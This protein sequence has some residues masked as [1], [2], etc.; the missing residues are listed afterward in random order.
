M[1]LNQ[2]TESLR[3]VPAID[4]NQILTWYQKA[5]NQSENPGRFLGLDEQTKRRFEFINKE[6]LGDSSSIKNDYG[7]IKAVLD[8]LK[9]YFNAIDNTSQKYELVLFDLINQI[10]RT[11]LDFTPKFDFKNQF[12]KFEAHFKTEKLE[13]LNLGQFFK[14]PTVTYST[15]NFICAFRQIITKDVIEKLDKAAEIDET[16]KSSNSSFIYQSELE[17]CYLSLIIKMISSAYTDDALSGVVDSVINTWLNNYPFRILNSKGDFTPDNFFIS[18]NTYIREGVVSVKERLRNY[19]DFFNRLRNT[20]TPAKVTIVS[21]VEFLDL[22]D[23]SNTY[24][25]GTMTGDDK[26]PTKPMRSVYFREDFDYLNS[27]LIRG[28][29]LNRTFWI[30]VDRIVNMKNKK[31]GFYLLLAN[32]IKGLDEFYD[33][34]V[35]DLGLKNGFT[36]DMDDRMERYKT[37]CETSDEKLELILKE[38]GK[39]EEEPHVEDT[40]E[41]IDIEVLT[42]TD[43]NK[44]LNKNI[45]YVSK[46]IVT[47]NNDIYKMH[48]EYSPN[49]KIILKDDGTERSYN[50]CYGSS[51]DFCNI[52][53]YHNLRININSSETLLK[54]PIIKV[55][56]KKSITK[57]KNNITEVIDKMIKDVVDRKVRIYWV[58]FTLQNIL[59]DG[60]ILSIKTQFDVL[61]SDPVSIKNL[62]N[63]FATHDKFL[64]LSFDYGKLPDETKP[65]PKPELRAD[66][67]SERMAEIKKRSDKLQNETM[68]KYKQEID[69]LMFQGRQQIA[70]KEQEYANARA[71]ELD[72]S[73]VQRLEMAKLKAESKAGIAKMKEE[74]EAKQAAANLLLKEAEAE[75]ER[76][77]ELGKKLETER[78]KARA[79]REAALEAERLKQKA[80]EEE[81][82]AAN[83]LDADIENNREI[84]EKGYK[85][86]KKYTKIF[87]KLKETFL[88]KYAEIETIKKDGPFLIDEKKALDAA[89]DKEASEF[90][91]IEA[92]HNSLE[93][94]R[95]EIIDLKGNDP[96]DKTLIKTKS[97]YLNEAQQRDPLIMV[98]LLVEE[99]SE[100]NKIL[101]EL[102]KT[103]KNYYESDEIAT[104]RAAALEAAAADKEAA[105]KARQAEANA[106]KSAAKEAAA[107]KKAANEQ[108]A[109]QAAAAVAPPAP[110]VTSSSLATVAAELEDEEAEMQ[111]AMEAEDARIAAEE[112]AAAVL[113]PAAGQTIE[114]Y[115]ESQKGIIIPTP[116]EFRA[117]PNPDPGYIAVGRIFYKKGYVILPESEAP[118]AADIDNWTKVGDYYF[119]KFACEKR[120]DSPPG[121]KL[122]KGTKICV[123]E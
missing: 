35:K 60:T 10:Y 5:S 73:D 45:A 102:N 83:A 88:K 8:N 67:F 37:I 1:A 113:A 81:A 85:E 3:T 78:E 27:L 119:K 93:I 38:F 13:M 86:M 34:I 91:E 64:I 49:S 100:K 71:R 47:Y 7:Q 16:N 33:T 121:Y 116:K 58:Y 25:R 22:Y 74:N 94:L 122:Q 65:I 59:T 42:K 120:A 114:K 66:T 48:V 77:K 15:V 72:A 80:A 103:I 29:N 63:T 21:P 117:N 9:S 12:P 11:D 89:V 79:A 61:N 110:L 108:V 92:G 76:L 32:N 68:V 46:E 95:K 2:W 23:A 53:A 44:Y 30:D 106:K 98:D 17:F 28:V 6:L 57:G 104:L 36:Q 24:D 41:I 97:T 52:I 54:E 96:P 14:K 112:A 87:E 84:I 31:L 101:E 19:F 50:Y 20:R 105:A 111:A 69:I 55:T 115:D 109:K 82:A 107:A 99:W 118:A 18:A 4:R 62:C 123:K 51:E 26:L 70:I 56:Y 43:Y 90:R 75:L 40:P 39:K